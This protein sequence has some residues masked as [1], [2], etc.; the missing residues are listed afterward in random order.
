MEKITFNINEFGLWKMCGPYNLV[1]LR[2]GRLVSQNQSLFCR[3]TYILPNI[4]IHLKSLSHTLS[5]TLLYVIFRRRS[6][7]P[8]ISGRREQKHPRSLRPLDQSFAKSWIP[9]SKFLYLFLSLNYISRVCF[10]IN[11]LSFLYNAIEGLISAWVVVVLLS[12]LLIIQLN[13]VFNVLP[14]RFMK[15]SKLLFYRL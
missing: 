1:K 4:S 15:F 11:F 12:N 10:I 9:N 7:F 13:F 2:K 14:F 8:A 6:H 5:N 3:S